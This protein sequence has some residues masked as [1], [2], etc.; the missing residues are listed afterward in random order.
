MRVRLAADETFD[1][2]DVACVEVFGFLVGD[3]VLEF[4]KA[5]VDDFVFT[6]FE[7]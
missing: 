7:K 6:F 1:F 4:V 3:E 5:L 2:E